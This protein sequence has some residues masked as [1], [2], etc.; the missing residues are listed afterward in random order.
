[1]TLILSN[2]IISTLHFGCIYM[3]N[4]DLVLEGVN[5]VVVTKVP[6]NV[7]SQIA[8]AVAEGKS[9]LELENA[10]LLLEDTDE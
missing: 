6:S 3:V 4:G 10:E 5:T 8:M 1:M 9:F 7:L 2:A